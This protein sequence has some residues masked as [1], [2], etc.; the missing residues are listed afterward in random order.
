L[1]KFNGFLDTVMRFIMAAAMFA[2]LAGGTWQIFTRWILKNPSTFTDEFLRYVLIWASMLGSAYCFYKDEHRVKGS[3]RPV[4]MIFIEAAILFFVCYV[5]IYGGMQ[6]AGNATNKSSVMRIPFRLL[7]ACL[8]ISG[9]FIVIARVIKYIQLFT[10]S[11]GG[12]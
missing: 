3:V 8:P 11:K 5:F 4:L 10:D 12:K 7:Y 2:L 9:I 1:K 6:L